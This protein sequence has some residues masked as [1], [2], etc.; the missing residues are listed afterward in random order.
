MSGIGCLKLTE[1]LNLKGVLYGARSF[2]A[3]LFPAGLFPANFSQ[4]GVFPARSSPLLFSPAGMFPAIFFKQGNQQNQMKPSQTEL[5]S[6]LIISNL[7][8]HNQ[9]KPSQTEPILT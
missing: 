1:I 2:P 8:Q 9:I 5:K 3:G 6:N 4:L 7:S